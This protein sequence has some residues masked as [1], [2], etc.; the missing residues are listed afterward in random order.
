MELAKWWTGT[1]AGD[2]Q[3]RVMIKTFF[4]LTRSLYKFYSD[5]DTQVG[6]AMLMDIN[7]A[8]GKLGK[9]RSDRIRPEHS[10]EPAE[11]CLHPFPNN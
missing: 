6:C 11:S 3:I 1:L 2:S 8:W 4:C 7:A 9:S 5:I 10:P